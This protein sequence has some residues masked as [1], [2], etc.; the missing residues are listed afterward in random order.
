MTDATETT[1]LAI[2]GIGELVNLE[3]GAQCARA[4]DAIRDLEW[5][6]RAAKTELTRA[7]VH[8][9]QQAGSKT[10][11]YEGVEA[12]V[13]GGTS[14]EYD[15]EA[16]YVDLL[17]AGMS[18]QRAGEIVVE[19]VS[20]KVSAREADRAAK[21]NPAYAEAISRHTRVVDTPYSVTVSV[22]KQ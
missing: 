22:K 4:I 5:Q 8:A 17:A 7:L 21:A 3:D 19:T 2:I 13:K 14:T 1:E 18:E 9:S 16:I 11:R 6:L 12:V 20:R 10:L 15:S